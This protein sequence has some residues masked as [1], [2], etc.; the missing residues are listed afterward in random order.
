MR[1]THGEPAV[2]APCSA[3]SSCPPAVTPWIKF[4][5]SSAKSVEDFE[6]QKNGGSEQKLA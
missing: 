4:P 1:S 2:P 5:R 6:R 3:D